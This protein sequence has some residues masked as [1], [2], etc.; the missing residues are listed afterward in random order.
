M[1]L[2]PSLKQRLLDLLLPW[3]QTHNKENKKRVIT[4]LGLE[5]STTVFKITSH[6]LFLLGGCMGGKTAYILGYGAMTLVSAEIDFL[7]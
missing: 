4:G 3:E 7:L 6:T 2:F 1:R 5:D